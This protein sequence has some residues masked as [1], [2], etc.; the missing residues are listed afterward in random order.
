MSAWCPSLLPMHHFCYRWQL[1]YLF[2]SLQRGVIWYLWHLVFPSF[3]NKINYTQENQLCASCENLNWE[4]TCGLTRAS[5]VPTTASHWQSAAPFRE[6]QV[7]TWTLH[8]G[9]SWTLGHW[10]SDDSA[11]GDSITVATV[12][13]TST[14][15]I[16]LAASA[17]YLWLPSLIFRSFSITDKKIFGRNLWENYCN[18]IGLVLSEEKVFMV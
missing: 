3:S 9:H 4:K 18:P 8:C 14:H 15:W 2:W 11:P 13:D 17:L 1:R 12:T 7:D 6:T 16:Q 5:Q 10:I